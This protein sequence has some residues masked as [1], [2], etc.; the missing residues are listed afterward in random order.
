MA[1]NYFAETLIAQ[2]DNLW[3]ADKYMRKSFPSERDIAKFIEAADKLQ[4]V[5]RI[6]SSFNG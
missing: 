3:S 4:I 5:P 6:V 2:M 1:E